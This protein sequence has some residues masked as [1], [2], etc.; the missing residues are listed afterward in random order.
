MERKTPSIIVFD[1]D[2]T[3]WNCWCDCT[4]GPYELVSSDGTSTNPGDIVVKDQYGQRIRLYPEV[5][6]VLEYCQSSL[7][8]VVLAVASR[9]DTPPQ[10]R[11]LLH[12][13]GL[14][15]HFRLQEIYPGD[16]KQ[17]M[18]RIAADA[19]TPIHSI[20]FFDDEERNVISTRQI[21]V[22]AVHVPDGL[23]SNSFTA[24][25]SHYHTQRL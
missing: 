3:L 2:L 7:P 17:H 11:A 1:L 16:K 20:L 10:A 14:H 12:H 21:G 22:V 6:S 8:D 5:A 18:R 15:S 19:G 13:F 9:T 25:L 4:T 23:T 24:G